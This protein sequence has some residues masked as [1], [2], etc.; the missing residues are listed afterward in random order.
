MQLFQK[1]LDLNRD[2]FKTY[3]ES[4]RDTID[5]FCSH[6]PDLTDEAWF[7]KHGSL[8][9]AGE[10]MKEKMKKESEEKKRK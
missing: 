9:K 6:D 3:Y 2:N 8:D 10:E 5:K 7:G 4:Y 1:R